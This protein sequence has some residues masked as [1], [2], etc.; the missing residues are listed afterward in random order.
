MMAQLQEQMKNMPPEQ[1]AQMEAM[2]KGRRRRA[3]AGMAAPVKTQYRKVGTGTVGK[4]TCDKYEGFTGEKKVSEVCTVDPKVL[5]FT[6]ADFAVSKQMAAFFK[7]IVPRC[8]Q[9]RQMFSVGQPGRAG[10]QRRA[11]PDRHHGRRGA[12][13]HDRNHRGQP[14]DVPGLGVPGPGGLPEDR[15][16]GRPRT[17]TRTVE[18]LIPIDP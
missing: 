12:R 15:L 13:R 5:G 2:M 6:A 8:R 16:H 9:S 7:K 1:R 4:W 3:M 18:S 11:G 10:L 17:G 14:P